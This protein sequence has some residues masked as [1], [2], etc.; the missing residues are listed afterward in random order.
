MGSAS[1]KDTKDVAAEN[2]REK[3]P[4]PK[5]TVTFDENV[6][7]Y[8]LDDKKEDR[9]N[10]ELKI[11]K[12]PRREVIGMDLYKRLQMPVHPESRGNTRYIELP[13]MEAKYGFKVKSRRDVNI[14]LGMA[15]GSF[16][17]LQ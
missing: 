17:V 3:V 6:T 8:D 10:Q 12:I 4:V 16:E 5:K 2:S 15:W 9:Q 14:Q 7:M 1:S 11:E 13:K